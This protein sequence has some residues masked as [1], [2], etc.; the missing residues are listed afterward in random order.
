MESKTYFS[1]EGKTEKHKGCGQ[2]NT[3]Y[4]IPVFILIA[5]G[6][7]WFTSSIDNAV[8]SKSDFYILDY[9]IVDADYDSYRIINF[10]DC[11]SVNSAMI[12]HGMME[13]GNFTTTL[14]KKVDKVNISNELSSEDIKEFCSKNFIPKPNKD[15]RIKELVNEL[16]ELLE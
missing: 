11:T 16:Q 12:S 1:K 3:R 15:E 7:I 14:F 8:A 4:L 2:M 10:V 9:P 13:T 5:F 6:C